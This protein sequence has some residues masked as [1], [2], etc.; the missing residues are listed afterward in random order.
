MCAAAKTALYLCGGEGTPTVGKVAETT[1]TAYALFVASELGR[2]VF[3]DDSA[4]ARSLDEG[5]LWLEAFAEATVVATACNACDS[6]VD[7]WEHVSNEVIQKAHD[8]ASHHV[9]TPV[10]GENVLML[11]SA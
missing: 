2:C 11:T 6:F 4:K 1:A 7:S 3:P 9:T 8:A 5:K 10:R